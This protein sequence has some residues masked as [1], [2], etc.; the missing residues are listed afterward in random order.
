MSELFIVVTA[1][2]DDVRRCISSF[3]FKVFSD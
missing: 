3:C 2:L 1:V